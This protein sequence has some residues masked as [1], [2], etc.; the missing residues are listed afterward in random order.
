MKD[1]DAPLAIYEGAQLPNLPQAIE[2]F[3][4]RIRPEWQATPL[5][6]RVRQLL[7]VDA[8][9]ACQRLLNAAGHDLRSKIRTLGLD[10]AK[11]AAK[12][13]RLPPVETDEDL[14][15][16]S[17]SRLYDLA[18]RL[19]LVNRAEWRRLHRTYEIRRDPRA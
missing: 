17:T 16:Y 4:A 1:P 7:P 13:F 6:Q 10:L 11:E 19:S 2:V 5:V 3:L 8:S 14:E 18:Y 9:S 15:N 12:A